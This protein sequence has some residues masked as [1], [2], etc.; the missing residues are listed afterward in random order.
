AAALFVRRWLR[1]SVA[2]ERGVPSG[3]KRSSTSV[4]VTFGHSSACLDSAWKKRCGVVPP[5]TA[6]RAWPRRAIAP[7]SAAATA[8]AS[9]SANAPGEGKTC[10]S[11]RALMPP[12]LRRARRAVACPGGAN[13]A[14]AG[15]TSSPAF[16]PGAAVALD[17]RDRAGRPPRAGGIALRRLPVFRPCRLDR[18]DPRPC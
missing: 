6:S 7:A 9:A 18:I 10:Q 2:L 1:T 3:T 15:A 17:Q 8:P 14:E 13:G 5:E 16:V 12:R 11:G 4:T